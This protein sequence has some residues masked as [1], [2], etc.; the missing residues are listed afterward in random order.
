MTR[1]ISARRRLALGGL[2][3]SLS[4]AL[5][6]AGYSTATQFGDDD[7]CGP[8]TNG[9]GGADIYFMGGGADCA[10]MF[11]SGDFL[12]GQGGSD[13]PLEG[14]EGADWVFGG[15]GGDQ[16]FGGQGGDLEEG[17]DDGDYVWDHNGIDTLRGGENG[18]IVSG[19]D[20]AGSDS[21]NGGAGINDFCAWDG[22]D[23]QGGCEFRY[24]D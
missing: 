22:G 19:D 16:V 11:G 21:V 7:N 2:V 6:Y 24:F 20:G 23:S 17:Q 1:V 8:V 12:D 5:A 10:Q 18:D 14:D 13:G 9:T 4:F 15:G 3:L